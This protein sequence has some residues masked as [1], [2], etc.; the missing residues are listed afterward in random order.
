MVAANARHPARVLAR[1][2]AELQISLARTKKQTD[3]AHQV[4]IIVFQEEVVL[5]L[6]PFLYKYRSVCF[7]VWHMLTLRLK[8][9]I[10]IFSLMLT[11]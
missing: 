7:K 1:P 10:L 6:P 3:F 11:L 5:Q 8:N 9:V 4:T 2:V